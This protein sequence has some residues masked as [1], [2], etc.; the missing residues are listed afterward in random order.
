[1]A[2]H[3]ALSGDFSSPPEIPACE[4][5]SDLANDV[6]SMTRKLTELEKLNFATTRYTGAVAAERILEEQL[7]EGTPFA[8]CDARI[9]ELGFIAARQ[10]YAKAT[11]LLRLTAYLLHVAARNHGGPGSFVGHAGG[12]SFIIILPPDNVQPF[13][14]AAIASFDAEVY[15]L[16]HPGET[17]SDKAAT[18]RSVPITTITIT[19]LIC[20][21]DE[22]TSA[23]DIT[24][25]LD[26]IK[27][28]TVRKTDAKRE[29][30]SEG[31]PVLG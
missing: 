19:T 11:D 26:T 24:R 27:E 28:K 17:V 9:D 25:A 14:E 18:P 22:A 31:S 23:A 7:K 4:E 15:R 29:T 8:L 21:V 2:T 1:M 16:F 3:R 20:G 12:D 6:T 13:C 10:G 30:P 5:I